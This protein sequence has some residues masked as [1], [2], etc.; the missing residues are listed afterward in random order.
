MYLKAIQLHGTPILSQQKVTNG[1]Q[2]FWRITRY[3]P[4]VNNEGEVFWV[5]I[6]S[7]DITSEVR[8]KEIGITQNESSKEIAWTQSHEIRRPVATI[9]GLRFVKSQR[10]C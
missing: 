6:D 10:P 3:E 4:T 5:S 7:T 2:E 1:S 9:L 8:Q